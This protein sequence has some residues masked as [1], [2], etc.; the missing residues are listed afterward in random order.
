MFQCFRLTIS[1]STNTSIGSPLLQCKQGCETH[2]Q[3]K[4]FAYRPHRAT[5]KQLLSFKSSVTVF[6]KTCFSR[7]TTST[8]PT[9]KPPAPCTFPKKTF[10]LYKL[11]Y[12]PTQDGVRQVLRIAAGRLDDVHLVTVEARRIWLQALLMRHATNTTLDL[13]LLPPLSDENRAADLSCTTS[14]C[15][16]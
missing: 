7:R 10:P 3:L 6:D 5:V 15:V 12:E 4:A 9:C 16:H 8:L 11:G 1:F 13:L 14:S 2:Y